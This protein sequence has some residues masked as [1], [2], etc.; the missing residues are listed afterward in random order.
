MGHWWN[1]TD[2]A[3]RLVSI[4]V[5]ALEGYGHIGARTDS[6]QQTKSCMGILGQICVATFIPTCLS[7]LLRI[8]GFTFLSLLIVYDVNGI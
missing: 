4:P 3:N 2:R 6:T 7:R 1:D 5:A 8:K